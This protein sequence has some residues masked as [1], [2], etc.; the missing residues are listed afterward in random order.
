MTDAER[1][2]HILLHDLRTPIGVAQGY[3]RMMQDGRLTAAAETERAVAK[4]LQALGQTARLCQDAGDFLDASS[5]PMRM[6]VV[7]AEAFVT[8]VES[9]ARNRG[10]EIQAGRIP[11]SARLA[12]A[13]DV[14]RIGDAVVHVATAT[15][16]RST[17]S[18]EADEAELRFLA[19]EEPG[20][21]TADATPFDG[22]SHGLPLAVACRRIAWSSGRVLKLAKSNGMI[23][24]FP[25]TSG[26]LER[27]GSV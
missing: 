4:A 8:Q 10:V 2:L 14:G 27:D 11:A 17:L 3:L 26:M 5:G 15:G 12:L 7:T 22:W 16:Q 19:V 24:A 13:G 23:V 6:A 20:S 25:L 21:S 1:V 9:Q 18:I